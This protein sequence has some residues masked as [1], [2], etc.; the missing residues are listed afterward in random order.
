MSSEDRAN[1][2]SYVE[3]PVEKTED[4][5]RMRQFYTDVF[6]WVYQNW[7]DAYADT[8]SSGVASGLNGDPAHR[9]RSPLVV[10]YTPNLEAMQEKVRSEGATIIKD[11]FSFP[12]GRRFH[13]R[14][15]AGNDLAVWSDK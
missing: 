4:L 9:A 7:G 2:I 12:G 15:P 1:K 3:L 6:G 13:F 8:K 14:D 5:A 10:I 11:I